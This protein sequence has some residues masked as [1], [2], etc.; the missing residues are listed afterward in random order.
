MQ[1]AS[2]FLFANVVGF[3]ESIEYLD[4]AMDGPCQAA[5]DH[6]D[7]A[8]RGWLAYIIQRKTRAPEK[9]A[10]NSLLEPRRVV[11]N[12][13][14]QALYGVVGIVERLADRDL[15]AVDKAVKA[16]GRLLPVVR[17]NN[18]GVAIVDGGADKIEVA[19]EK[20]YAL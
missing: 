7:L 13:C 1:L 16:I 10:H 17:A 14:L 5:R 15:R 2:K 12:L 6:I 11:R 18:P 20:I 9:V 4:E 8:A 19:I 3:I